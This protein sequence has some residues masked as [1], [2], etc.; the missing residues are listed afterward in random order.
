MNGHR[1][2]V[3]SGLSA[4]RRTMIAISATVS[5]G[6]TTTPTGYLDRVVK[7]VAPI[8][9]V[10]KSPSLTVAESWLLTVILGVVPT[11]PRTICISATPASQEGCNWLAD[12]IGGPG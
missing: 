5:G 9:P 3:H 6:T 1:V 4:A 7:A 11:V 12:V 8:R 10:H 2:T